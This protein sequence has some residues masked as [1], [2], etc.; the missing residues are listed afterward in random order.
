MC[1]VSIGEW[2]ARESDNMKGKIIDFYSLPHMKYDYLN[3]KKCSASGA[4][5][6]DLIKGINSSYLCITVTLRSASHTLVLLDVVVCCLGAATGIA[7]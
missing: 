4:L 6:P 7:L 3:T 1:N 5:P 2:N